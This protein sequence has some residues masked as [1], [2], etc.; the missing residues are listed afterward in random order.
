MRDATMKR[1]DPVRVNAHA[2]ASKVEGIARPLRDAGKTLRE[3]AGEL[4][5]ARVATARGGKWQALQIK[6]VLERL[7]V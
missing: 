2:R 3:I 5:R 4:N 6:R 7:D 1:N